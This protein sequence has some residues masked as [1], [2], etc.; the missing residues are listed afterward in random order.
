MS[1]KTMLKS[2]K[3]SKSRLTICMLILL[4][5]FVPCEVFAMG[6]TTRVSISSTGVQGNGIYT[7]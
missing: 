5:L 4:E 7:F 1:R 2:I 6:Q 3:I